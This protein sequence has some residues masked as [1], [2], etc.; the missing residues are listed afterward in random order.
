LHHL[1]YAQ[2]ATKAAE[3]ASDRQG[4]SQASDTER[5]EPQMATT[6]VEKA[7]TILPKTGQAEITV[8]TG[9]I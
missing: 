7:L 4:A 8:K 5:T 2:L 1:G 6:K 3:R 9:D